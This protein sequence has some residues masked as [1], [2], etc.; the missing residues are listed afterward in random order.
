MDFVK[1]K[2][3]NL[4]SHLLGLKEIPMQSFLRET[5]LYKSINFDNDKGKTNWT[6]V[7]VILIASVLS[8]IVI[9]WLISRKVKCYQVNILYLLANNGLIVMTLRG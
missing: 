1:F 2:S 6:L 7:T 8:T 3:L 9:G 4:P 5:G